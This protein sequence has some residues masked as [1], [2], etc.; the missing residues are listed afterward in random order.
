MPQCW[1][2]AGAILGLAEGKQKSVKL[3]F[4]G[5]LITQMAGEFDAHNRLQC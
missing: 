1:R 4:V 2:M 3:N 5:G